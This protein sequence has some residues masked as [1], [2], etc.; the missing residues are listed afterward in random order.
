MSQPAVLPPGQRKATAHHVCDSDA[1]LQDGPSLDSELLIAV[2]V[3]YLR[4][5]NK[6]VET[7]CAKCTHHVITGHKAVDVVKHQ[8]RHRHS[9]RHHA[10]Y[11]FLVRGQQKR[12]AAIAV[13]CV[14]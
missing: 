10:R 6:L 3:N 5:F 7:E 14:D 4:W 12:H 9:S 13:L 2:S 1:K 11:C 8:R